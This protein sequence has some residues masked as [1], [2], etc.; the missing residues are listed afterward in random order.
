[1]ASAFRA[2]QGLTAPYG[3]MQVVTGE[4]DPGWLLEGA[5]V[6]RPG[7]DLRLGSTGPPQA[8]DWLAFP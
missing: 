4:D 5:L 1:M 2:G 8:G 3:I 7:R 6:E